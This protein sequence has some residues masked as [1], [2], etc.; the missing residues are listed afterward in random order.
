[1]CAKSQGKGWVGVGGG[2]S[3]DGALWHESDL[4]ECLRSL[5][6]TSVQEQEVED[7]GEVGRSQYQI[8]KTI[9]GFGLCFKTSGRPDRFSRGVT[10]SDWVC[11]E[12]LWLPCCAHTGT[13][14]VG[15]SVGRV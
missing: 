6:K 4:V 2:N 14:T 3:L 9:L 7:D 1:M 11:E 12:S 15:S 10:Q 13:G 8:L 5:Q